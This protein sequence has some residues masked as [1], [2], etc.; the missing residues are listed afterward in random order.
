MDK[1][2]E[3]FKT[4]IDRISKI[5]KDYKS[6]EDLENY[7]IKKE[8]FK[9]ENITPFKPLSVRAYFCD[10]CNEEMTEYW[11]YSEKCFHKFCKGDCIEC[12]EISL[13]KPYFFSINKYIILVYDGNDSLYLNKEFFRMCRATV[14]T[15]PRESNDAETI[16][17]IDEAIDVF[18]TTEDH[19]WGRSIHPMT[20]FWANCSNIQA[21]ENND[22]N[23]NIIHT[24]LGFPLLKKLSQLGDPIAKRNYREEIIR[25]LR[26]N[27]FNTVAYL[28]LNDFLKVFNKNEI[29]TIIEDLD[30]HFVIKMIEN[31]IEL[32]S[33]R[34]SY[35]IFKRKDDYLIKMNS[36]GVRFK[37]F[38][39]NSF[40]IQFI[41]E[42]GLV[43]RKMNKKEFYKK[44][45]RVRIFDYKRDYF[46]LM[47]QFYLDIDDV[48]SLKR[49]SKNRDFFKTTKIRKG[50]YKNLID[51]DFFNLILKFFGDS[52]NL[53]IFIPEKYGF[54]YIVDYELKLMAIIRASLYNEKEIK[55]DS[56]FYSNHRRLK[57]EIKH[58]RNVTREYFKT[59]LFQFIKYI[60]KEGEILSL[61]YSGKY[62]QILRIRF[63]VKNEDNIK[64]IIKNIIF[65]STEPIIFYRKILEDNIIEYYFSRK[66]HHK[67][68]TVGWG[69]NKELVD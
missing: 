60:T 10:I 49:D 33:E 37:Y 14:L 7:P 27:Y 61:K 1:M 42:R 8:C 69:K 20:E 13:K 2:A 24:N 22:Y 19:G 6:R 3:K 29:S 35:D 38:K 11:V 43:L 52:P 66:E 17:S 4:I 39:D 48:I 56:A 32:F 45:K 30:D 9:C 50:N 34:R 54:F 25:R 57:R 62:D 41:K 44:A 51:I 53:D 40:P 55:E 31:R 67:V 23:T 16:D 15:I 59:K 46:D 63:K 21:W 65:N 68:K 64:E 18:S 26:S 47:S 58:Y 5:Y 28:I 36:I 12:D